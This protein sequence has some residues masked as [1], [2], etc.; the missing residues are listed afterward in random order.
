MAINE[1]KTGKRFGK[2]DSFIIGLTLFGLTSAVYNS[3]PSAYQER[4]KEACRSMY[5]DITHLTDL[6]Y[7]S[8]KMAEARK[9]IVIESNGNKFAYLKNQPNRVFELQK[10]VLE[11]ERGIDSL[12]STDLI[13]K[14]NYR[15]A[16]INELEKF[17][18]SELERK[19]GQKL[20]GDKLTPGSQVYVPVRAISLADISHYVRSNN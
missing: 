16:F 3:L 20:S 5:G 1:H 14:T 19:K 6:D 9:M 12:I 15:S 13:E 2:I 7:H 8:K 17:Y 4:I 18:L 10:K 11:A